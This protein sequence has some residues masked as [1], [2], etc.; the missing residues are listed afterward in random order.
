MTTRDLKARVLEAAHGAPSAT[1]GTSRVQAWLVLPS[2]VIVAA[3]LFFALGGVQNGQGRPMWFYLASSLGWGAVAALSTWGALGRGASATWRTRSILVAV[4]IGTPAVLFAMMFAFATADPE[5]TQ[6]HP[7]RLG[8]KCLGLT[9][10]AATFPLL[11]LLAVRR[12]SDPVHPAATGAA[13]GAACGA[14]AGV[15]VEM[16]CPVSEL[17]HVAFGHIAPIVLL[18]LVGAALGS[19]VLGMRARGRR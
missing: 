1:R 2:S 18:A 11:S 14:S 5:L 4:A 9:V 8:L 13:L 19:R 16:W 10:A 12:G 6:V 7:E 3:S 17:R 15:M